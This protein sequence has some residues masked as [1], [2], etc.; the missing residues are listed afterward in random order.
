[1]LNEIKEKNNENSE[2]EIFGVFYW[3]KKATFYRYIIKYMLVRLS[4]NVTS[5]MLPYYLEYILGIKKTIKGGTPIQISLIYLFTTTG[6]LFNSLYLQKFF[7]K[8]IDSR[9]MLMFIFWIFTTTG[10]LPILFLTPSFNYPI[11]FLG[12]LF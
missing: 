10:L 8:Y 7:E 6:C 2:P 3:L 4:I 12:F 5:S 1:L 11:Y 9:M